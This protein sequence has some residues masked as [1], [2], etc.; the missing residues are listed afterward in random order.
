MNFEFD[1][2]KSKR[3]RLKHGIDFVDAQEIWEDDNLIASVTD[4][5][6]EVRFTV[7]GVVNSRHWAAFITYRNTA[8][9]IISVRRARRQE[10]AEYEAKKDHS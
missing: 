2:A 3:N 5:E 9:R 10:V 8:V 4:F 1:P 7:I 6:G